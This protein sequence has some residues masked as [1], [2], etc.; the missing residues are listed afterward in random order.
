MST[1]GCTFFLHTEHARRIAL[2]ARNTTLHAHYV[3]KTHVCPALLHA[4]CDRSCWCGNEARKSLRGYFYCDTFRALVGSIPLRK[5]CSLS[6]F[7]QL[8]SGD[9]LEYDFF[10]TPKEGERTKIGPL[11]TIETL[12][13]QCGG[14]VFRSRALFWSNGFSHLST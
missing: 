9:T 14:L 10:L 1:R 11:T 8:V 5:W 2:H 13:F 6:L 3:M 4:F 12:R 7:W